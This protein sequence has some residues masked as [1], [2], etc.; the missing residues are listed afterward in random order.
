MV[1][2][3]SREQ[4]SLAALGLGD[5]APNVGDL[6]MTQRSKRL[7]TLEDLGDANAASMGGGIPTPTN[8]HGGHDEKV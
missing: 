7:K 4:T 2:Q 5:V 8:E 1:R 3:D 6:I